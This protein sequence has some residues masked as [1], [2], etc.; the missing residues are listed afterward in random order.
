MRASVGDRLIIKGHN[1]GDH[2]RDAEILEVQGEDGGPPYLVRWDEDGHEGLFFPG[3]D[4]VGS[5]LSPPRTS[6]LAMDERTS[7][8]VKESRSEGGCSRS[9]RRRLRCAVAVLDVD[10]PNFLC[11]GC[12]RC[13]H[14]E[15]GSCHSRN[16][17]S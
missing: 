15:L 3:S 13:W 14:V 5:T 11:G 6:A 16:R 9:A 4:A 12:G 17:Y 1:V 10:E 7:G 8:E 2:D